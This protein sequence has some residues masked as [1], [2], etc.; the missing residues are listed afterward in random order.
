MRIHGVTAA[1]G[2]TVPGPVGEVIRHARAG[3]DLLLP[4]LCPGCH[5]PGSWCAGCAATIAGRPRAVALPD[6]MLDRWQSL[7]LPMVPVHALARYTGPV[8]AAIVAG[9]EYGRR[10]LPPR[11]GAALGDGLDAL[12]SQAVIPAEVYLVPA[13]SRKSAARAR[14]GDPVLTMARAAAARLAESGRSAG[15]ASCLYL[16]RRTKD[17]VGLD[18]AGRAD[19]LAGAVRFDRRMAPPVG[20]AAVLIDD[21]LTSGATALTSYQ[22]LQAC[23][24]PL[25][26]MLVLAAVP[27]LREPLLHRAA[28]R[29][30]ASQDLVPTQEPIQ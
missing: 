3:L 10:D 11:L 26:G 17:S 29:Q 8:R 15:V 24:V 21:V 27:R 14:D 16:A 1:K 30:G 7:G 18:G 28:R 23:G 2:P 22:A 5:A 13:P 20:T 4:R 12:M 6:M 25:T 9:K 19:N